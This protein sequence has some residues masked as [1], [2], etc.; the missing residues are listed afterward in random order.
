VRERPSTRLVPDGEEAC[1]LLLLTHRLAAT[2]T[3][4]P[5]SSDARRSG[6]VLVTDAPY[7]SLTRYPTGPHSLTVRGVKPR[8]NLVGAP[9]RRSPDSRMN[10]D[11]HECLP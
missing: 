9:R 8:A 11:P 3:L 5:G 1:P 6:T 2:E 4:S 7:E 10:I